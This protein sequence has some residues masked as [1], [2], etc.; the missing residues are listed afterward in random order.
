MT[1]TFHKFGVVPIELYQESAVDAVYFGVLNRLEGWRGVSSDDLSTICDTTILGSLTPLGLEQT[2]EWRLAWH[3]PAGSEGEPGLYLLCGRTGITLLHHDE[4]LVQLRQRD[5]AFKLADRLTLWL[6]RDRAELATCLRSAGTL[7]CL[8]SLVTVGEKDL[9]ADREEYAFVFA[10]V[11]L[12]GDGARQVLRKIDLFRTVLSCMELLEEIGEV[13]V[14]SEGS[15]QELRSF[16]RREFEGLAPETIR[17]AQRSRYDRLRDPTKQSG[18]VVDMLR[19]IDAQDGGH[20][21]SGLRRLRQDLAE[22]ALPHR[23]YQPERKGEWSDEHLLPSATLKS[24]ETRWLRA[25]W[26]TV[27]LATTNE[28][29]IRELVAMEVALQS[30]WSKFASATGAILM[31]HEENRPGDAFED[32]LLDRLSDQLLRVANWQIQLSD[33]QRG[34]FSRLRE[35]SRLDKNIDDFYEASAESVRRSAVVREKRFQRAATIVSVALAAIV[36]GEITISIAGE[37]NEEGGVEST[38]AILVSIGTGVLALW[39]VLQTFGDWRRWQQF[40]VWC[41]A[42]LLLAAMAASEP[43]LL[44]IDIPNQ[45][46]EIAQQL[47]PE[48]WWPSAGLPLLGLTGGSFAGVSIAFAGVFIAYVRAGVRARSGPRSSSQGGGRRPQ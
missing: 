3:E 29:S 47:F 17:K 22:A 5:D 44:G 25:R 45:P 21:V 10:A 40:V 6:E 31:I 14:F 34:V 46:R 36:L 33:W 11:D 2:G 18:S 19:A 48:P 15:M 37:G 12:G 9:I 26:D 20:G 39:F 24:G 38:V 23:D 7:K 1:A 35:T 27:V 28:S 4:E 43:P 8:K 42:L 13:D 41:A 32:G 16:L 30:A